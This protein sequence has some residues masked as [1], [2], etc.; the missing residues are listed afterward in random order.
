MDADHIARM[1]SDV[2]LRMTVEQR[3]WP[4]IMKPM[5]WAACWEWQAS[6]RREGYGRFKIFS[7]VTVSAHRLSYALFYGVSPGDLHVLHR[8][9]NPKCVNPSHLFLGTNA[10]NVADK[11]SKGR[12]IGRDQRGE[13]NAAAKLTREAVSDIRRRIADSQTNTSIAALYG[14]THQLISRIRRGRSWAGVVGME[15]VEPST[16]RV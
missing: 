7:Y 14:V 4:K 12:C 6:K 15:G 3:F 8:C 16:S 11:V 1:L 2:H 10:D 13:K 5:N 9:D